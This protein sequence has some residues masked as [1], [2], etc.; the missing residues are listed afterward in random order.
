MRIGS[1]E[2][3]IEEL[4]VQNNELHKELMQARN[5]TGGHFKSIS[6]IPSSGEEKIQIKKAS[7]LSSSD[8]KIVIG[9]IQE[10]LKLQSDDPVL[11]IETIR[12]LEKVVK[13]VPRMETFI[14]NIC[15]QL[16]DET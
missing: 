1:L 3:R 8:A 5:L 2:H 10:V 6:A 11:I 12:K 13:A 16:S 4:Q 15:K 7:T 14:S 9:E